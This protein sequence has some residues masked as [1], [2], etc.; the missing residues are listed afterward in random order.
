[1]ITRK[2]VTMS[3]KPKILKEL[4]KIAK[5]FNL[6]RGETIGKLIGGINGSKVPTVAA[7][8]VSKISKNQVSN[9]NDNL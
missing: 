4:D 5:Q 8:E 3:I 7:K 1:M 6:S 9:Q 2:I